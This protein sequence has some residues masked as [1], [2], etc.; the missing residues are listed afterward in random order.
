MSHDDLLSC[1]VTMAL[2]VTKALLENQECLELQDPQA[3]RVTRA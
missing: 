1:R 3:E 2:K